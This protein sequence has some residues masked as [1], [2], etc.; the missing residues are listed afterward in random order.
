MK[1]LQAYVS[2]DK[3]VRETLRTFTDGCIYGTTRESQP[4]VVITY[5]KNRK[6]NKPQL[7]E[8]NNE[9]TELEG[10]LQREI[11]GWSDIFT[12]RSL[13]NQIK[14]LESLIENESQT[15][16]LQPAKV[17]VNE[18]DLRKFLELIDT[19]WSCEV[20]ESLK[21]TGLRLNEFINPEVEK[22]SPQWIVEKDRE[23]WSDLQRRTWEYT[24]TVRESE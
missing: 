9:I 11:E 3:T 22:V 4:F 7:D 24:G 1:N 23:T 15:A 18:E 13:K 12:I 19:A 5:S 16:R 2:N 10:N 8:W 17:V 6:P 14:N 20:Y 21:N